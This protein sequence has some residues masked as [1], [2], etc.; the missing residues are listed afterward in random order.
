MIARY[1]NP[2]DAL[3]YVYYH[4]ANEYKVIHGQ[5][6]DRNGLPIYWVINAGA[7]KLLIGY[8]FEEVTG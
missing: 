7:A 4:G 1:N 3:N 5:V 6:K 2:T 8:G